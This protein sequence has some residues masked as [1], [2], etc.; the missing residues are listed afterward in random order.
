MD[1]YAVSKFL[2]V[3]VAILWLGGAAGMVLAGGRAMR[4]SR[5]EDVLAIVRQVTFLA[6]AVFMPGSVVILVLGLYL[7]WAQWSFADAWVVIGILGV[8]A[9][10]GIGGA[11]L[12]PLAKRIEAAGQGDEA[13][14]L[15]HE[16]LRKARAD[17]VLLF[18]IVWDMVSK[19]QWSDWVEILAMA[20]VVALGAALFLLKR[21]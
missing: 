10:G 3:A 13:I 19:P 12:T 17:M 21:A 7:T 8:V 5:S 20:A 9:T 1:L 2:H 15:S 6:G 16:L 18:V 14:T 4:L 11:I